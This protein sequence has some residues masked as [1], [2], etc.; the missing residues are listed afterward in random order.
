[1]EP[2]HL[3]HHRDMPQIKRLTARCIATLGAL[4]LLAGCG[5]VPRASTVPMRV[6]SDNAVCASPPS[7]LLVMLP[8]ASSLPEEF[9]REGF[10]RALRERRFAVDVLL[11]DAHPG[12]YK[13]R[14]VLD[15]LQADV[16]APARAKGY[17]K[18][19]LVGVSLGGLGALIQARAQ[20]ADAD[21]LML[22][23]PYLGE[24]RVTDA[25][26][27]DGGLKAWRGAVPDPVPDDVDLRLW[28]WLQAYATDPALRPP[29]VLGYA[30]GDRLAPANQLLA[31]SLPPDKVF[32][33]AGGH[34]W[35]EWRLL[36]NRMLDRADLPVDPTCA[37]PGANQR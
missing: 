22:L 3:G 8:G 10:V 6:L 35:P 9:L 2:Q 23:A 4:A 25:V 5:L 7:T 24:R 26:Q 17:R 16:I 33:T 29:L 21:G 32:T 30:L 34:D 31:N 19:W 36:W 14:T 28:R 37:F 15:R 12:Y 13:D 18:I 11:V 1:V 20:P 27:A